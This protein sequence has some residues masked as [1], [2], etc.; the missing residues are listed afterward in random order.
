[1]ELK[2]EFKNSTCLSTEDLELLCQEHV[3]GCV[4]CRERM[5]QRGV[6][7]IY[8]RFREDSE[9]EAGIHWNTGSRRWSSW[10]TNLLDVPRKRALQEYGTAMS[11][12]VHGKD[13]LHPDLK[14]I[15]V[16]RFHEK[17]LNTLVN[18]SNPQL[19]HVFVPERDV[20]LVVRSTGPK[21]KK[22]EE[23][24]L[25]YLKQMYGPG[26]VM[27]GSSAT[28]RWSW[29]TGNIQSGYV[30]EWQRRRAWRDKYEA[31]GGRLSTDEVH[32][33]FS[34]FLRR[35]ADEWDKKNGGVK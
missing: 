35:K 3:D 16:V 19:A 24:K 22:S 31:A 13:V 20:R 23:E 34:E 10:P 14:Q 11:M 1:M 28:S 26:R 27:E 5:T 25:A 2:L 8:L 30:D 7:D 32:E 12:M 6:R 29:D 9:S 33:T 15:L 21:V 4:L 18:K 17:I